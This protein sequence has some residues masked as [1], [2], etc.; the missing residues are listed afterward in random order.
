MEVR[1][2][3]QPV[4][5]GAL[6]GVPERLE[7]RRQQRAP[8]RVV[9]AAARDGEGEVVRGRADAGELE[10]DAVERAVRVLDLEEYGARV[11]EIF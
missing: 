2:D 9:A 5:I 4:Y 7:V 1:V 10:V 6:R 8:L 11:Y 3:H